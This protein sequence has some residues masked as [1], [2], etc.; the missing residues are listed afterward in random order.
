MSFTA[1]QLPAHHTPFGLNFRRQ[2]NGAMH[3][4]TS[5][6]VRAGARQGK[7]LEVHDYPDL[8][9]SHDREAGVVWQWMRPR[10]RAS[11]TLDLL[12][13]LRGAREQVE[14]LCA[15]QPGAVRYAVTGSRVPGVFNLGGDLPHFAELIR[16]GD[17]EALRAYAHACID[18]KFG[19][20][21]PLVAPYLSISLVQ[22]DALGGGFERALADDVIVAERGT[23]FGL[24]EVMFGLFP[25]MGAYSYLSRKL[26]DA[27][28]ERMIL[29]GRIYSAEDLHEMG[30]VTI[31]AE[32]G[33]GEAAV[34]TFVE[35]EQRTFRARRALSSIRQRVQPVTRAEL[36]DITDAWVDAAMTL[37]TGEL[38]KMERLANA[39]TRR[40]RDAGPSTQ[41]VGTAAE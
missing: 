34:K 29:S 24:P 33:E 36:I 17:R 20:D 39:Q 31:L 11:F 30:L 6:G 7:D 32:P 14:A 15:E 5:P 38:R 26:G 41:A 22:G 37:G 12:H 13:A 2:R 3:A 23:K 4:G 1:D 27:M 18:V 10:G 21:T 25:G 28:A 35:R 16:N 40:L 19:P 8:E 9:V